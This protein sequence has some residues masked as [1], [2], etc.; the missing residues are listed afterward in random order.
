MY[1]TDNKA[2][3]NHGGVCSYSANNLGDFKKLLSSRNY[4]A[5]SEPLSDTDGD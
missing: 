5:N 1:R 3:L 2:A 4:A